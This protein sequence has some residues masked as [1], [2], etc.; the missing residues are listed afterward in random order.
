MLQFSGVAP[1]DNLKAKIS[2]RFRNRRI[3]DLAKHVIAAALNPTNLA[4][5]R[6]FFQLGIAMNPDAARGNVH[7]RAIKASGYSRQWCYDHRSAC[8]D[9]WFRPSFSRC[10]YIWL[11]ELHARFRSLFHSSF[12]DRSGPW[13]NKWRAE[14]DI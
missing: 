1:M 2:T 14:L 4:S 11:P 9:P 3:A 8:F 7:D 10:D 12:C 6:Q 5:L 13:I